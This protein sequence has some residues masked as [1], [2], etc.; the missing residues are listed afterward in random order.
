MAQPSPFA[1]CLGAG[2]VFISLGVA[3]CAHPYGTPASAPAARIDPGTGVLNVADA[4][5]AGNDPAMALQVSQSVLAT[6]P[7][8]IQ[9]LYHEAAAYYAVGRCEDAVAAYRLALGIDPKSSQAQTGI[10]RCLLQHDAAAAEHA[11]AAAVRDDPGNAVALNDLGIARDL[12]GN[13]TGA[14]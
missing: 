9:A 12:Q 1:R 11:F 6:D 8:N 3:G 10:G 7:R 4:A 13:Y 14:T 5:I 2:V